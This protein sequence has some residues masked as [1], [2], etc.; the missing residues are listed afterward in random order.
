[1]A[2]ITD[3]SN[4]VLLTIVLY[5]T[6]GDVADVRALLQLCRTSHLLFAVAQPALYAHVRI[7]EPVSEPLAPVSYTH[8]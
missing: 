2:R 6:T 4:E 3:L 7:P 8:L 5:L 1:M